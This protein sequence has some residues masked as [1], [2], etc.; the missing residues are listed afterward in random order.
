MNALEKEVLKLIGES[1]ESPDVFTDDSTG[2][3]QIRD[4]IN[5]G[6]WM[7]TM[8]TGGYQKRYVLPLRNDRLFYR[9]SWEGDYFGY[10]IQAWDRERHKKLEQTDVL[11]LSCEDPWWMQ[12]TGYVE[13]YFHIGYQFLG[14]YRKPSADNWVLELDCACIPKAYSSDTDP[15][16]LRQNF[17]RAV[18]QFAVSEYH[19]S[20]GDGKRATEWLNQS[21]ET[22]GLKK[23]NPQMAERQYQ[24]GGY[25]TQGEARK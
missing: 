12:R 11:K 4:S 7:I 9:I 13:K 21:I 18:I 1:V 8:A 3:A 5:H 16:K 6:I 17:E 14:I 19:A 23:L 15:I 25:K 24:F 22:A 10:V 2:M 20:R